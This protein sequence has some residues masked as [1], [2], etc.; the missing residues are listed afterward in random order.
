MQQLGSLVVFFIEMS[1]CQ[2]SRQQLSLGLVCELLAVSFLRILDSPPRCAHSCG[3]GVHTV[4]ESLQCT[5]ASKEFCCA[6]QRSHDR[7]SVRE[8]QHQPFLSRRQMV[9]GLVCPA[10]HSQAHPVSQHCRAMAGLLLSPC[11][12]AEHWSPPLPSCSLH[13]WCCCVRLHH[14]Q[15]QTL[16]Y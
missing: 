12:P 6:Q 10:P 7:I 3:I 9:G 13:L 2:F 8:S 15:V 11:H 4:Q 5:V 14:V 1:P 16:F